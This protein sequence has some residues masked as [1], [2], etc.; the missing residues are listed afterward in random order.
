M[1]NPD[2]YK[3]QI[4]KGNQKL[5]DSGRLESRILFG[6]ERIELGSKPRT[7]KCS[8]CGAKGR[9]EIHHIKYHKD[10]PL[11]DTIEVCTRC[12]RKREQKLGEWK[13]G[14]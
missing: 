14:K 4:Q 2:K 13:R 9:T 7:S 6:K 3:S 12:H 8:M 1:N 5:K 10:N 11:K